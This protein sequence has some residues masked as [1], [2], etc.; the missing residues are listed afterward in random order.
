MPNHTTN[1]VEVRGKLNRLEE[2]KSYVKQ[3]RLMVKM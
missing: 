2:F 1:Y 3:M